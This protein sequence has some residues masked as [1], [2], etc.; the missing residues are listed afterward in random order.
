MKRTILSLSLG[1]AMAMQVN[2]QESKTTIGVLPVESTDGKTYKETVEITETVTNAFVKTQRF[3]LVERSKMDALKTEKKL[4]KG[5]DFID[6]STVEQSKSLGAQFLISSTLGSYSNNGE[7]CKFTLNLKVI[8]VTTGQIIN[9]EAIEAKGGSS[10]GS[11]AGGLTGAKVASNNPEGVLKKALKDILPA[12]DKFVD[13]NFPATFSLTEIQKKDSKG[14]A[15]TVLISGGS[16]MG[17]SKGEKLKIVE[18]MEVEVNGKKITRKKEIGEIKIT[19]VED[20]NFS[21]C[22]VMMGGADITAKFDAK[23]KIKVIT[24]AKD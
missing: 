9:S 8:D 14:A 12:I 21:I 22:S 23:A 5:E 24:L 10:A 19:K 7:V 15:E 11:I 16:S 20:E 17:L 1:F 4:Q 3:I 2:A 18:L 6:G 13:K